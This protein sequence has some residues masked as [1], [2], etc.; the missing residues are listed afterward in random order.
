MV[1]IRPKIGYSSRVCGVSTRGKRVKVKGKARLK[2][3]G[4]RIK[5]RPPFRHAEPT[6]G[7]QA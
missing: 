2:V 5:R 4:K 3:K 1:K 6:C 7:R